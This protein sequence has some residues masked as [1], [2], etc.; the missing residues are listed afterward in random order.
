MSDI[1]MILR[2]TVSKPPRRA[3]YTLSLASIAQAAR[4]GIPLGEPLAP[5]AAELLYTASLK[6]REAP[7]FRPRSP[8]STYP[9]LV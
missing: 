9:P 4:K 7:R 1:G 3:S 6:A 2:V 5:V 8:G